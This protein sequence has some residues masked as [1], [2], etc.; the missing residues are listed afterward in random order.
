MLPPYLAHLP[1]PPAEAVALSAELQKHI[2]SSI[3]ASG[4]WISFARF[5]ELALYAPG[6]GYYTAGSTKLGAAGDF[7]TA[8]ELSPLFGR[9]VARQVAQL[10]ESGITDV[11]EVGAGSGALARDVL[12]TLATLGRLPERYLILELSADLRERQRHRIAA[13]VPELIERVQWLDT[14][15]AAIH[16]VVIG[17][18]ILDAVPTHIVRTRGKASIDEAGVGINSPGDG[19]ERIYRPASGP[20]LA[21]AQ[22]L[23]LPADYEAEINLTARALV[24]DFAQR[25]ERG[26]L[27]FCDYGFPAAEYYHPQRF[28][29]T[30]MCHYRHHAHDDPLVLVGLQ[31][32]TSHVDFT[33]VADAAIDAGQTVLGYTT[34]AQFLINCGITDLLA[35][36]SVDDAR[37]W[38]PLAA[39][40]Q[41]LLSPAEMGELFKVLAFGR[42]VDVPLLGFT[43]GNRA[44][45]L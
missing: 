19:F 42:G 4:G 37:A 14:L 25:V 5:M 30:L 6:L 18:E 35:A 20:L 27:L 45:T 24:K 16:A 2:R 41:K 11:M 9:C 34:Q 12:Q 33:A 7:V 38:A 43:R 36:S 26:A 17:N 40:A 10:V 21:A 31:D 39:A 3:E 1:S 13:V 22:A 44:H 15:P 32:I 8:P 23:E 28:R 29:G